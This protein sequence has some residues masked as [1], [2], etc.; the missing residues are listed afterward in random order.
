MIT[1]PA[2]PGQPL[3][4]EADSL[5]FVNSFAGGREWKKTEDGMTGPFD[6][7]VLNFG[8]GEC[9]GRPSSLADPPN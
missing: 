8:L 3:A 5:V 9:A 4:G 6:K 1:R 2:L 7:T